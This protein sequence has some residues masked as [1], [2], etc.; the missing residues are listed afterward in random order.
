MEEEVSEEEI[1]RRVKEIEAARRFKEGRM[2]VLVTFK[3][4]FKALPVLLG[5]MIY[6][7]REYVRPPLRCYRCQRYGHVAARRAGQLEELSVKW[8]KG[9]KE[10]EKRWQS[11]LMKWKRQLNNAQNFTMECQES[12]RQW[13]RV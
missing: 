5:Y 12:N 13:T 2:S 8:R 7:V 11:G 9:K 1:V 3:Q 10:I 6:P 4:E